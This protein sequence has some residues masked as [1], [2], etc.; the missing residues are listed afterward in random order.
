MSDMGKAR[1][2]FKRGGVEIWRRQKKRATG[3]QGPFQ[4]WRSVTSRGEQLLQRHWENIAMCISYVRYDRF[5]GTGQCI[6][7]HACYA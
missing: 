4:V 7:V 6:F 2:A 3:D 5:L 1:H